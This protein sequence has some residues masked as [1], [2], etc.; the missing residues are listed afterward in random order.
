MSD[1]LSDIKNTAMLAR[2]ELDEAQAQ[3]LIGQLENILE[4]VNQINLVDTDQTEPLAH[5]LGF[6]QPVRK[7]V[8]T[9]SD[10]R[11]LFQKNAP[12]IEEGLYIVPKIIEDE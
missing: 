3:T 4:M 7:D 8:V 12:A 10:Q 2:L 1:F 6:Q 5:P 11:E 9:D